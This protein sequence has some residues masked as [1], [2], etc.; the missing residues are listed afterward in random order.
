M[1]IAVVGGG[2]FGVSAAI[3]LAEKHTVHLYER[4]DDILKGA[5]GINQYRLHRGYHYPRS[6]HTASSSSSSESSFRKEF[7]QAILDNFDHYYC[8]AKEKS[9]ISGQNFLQFCNDNGLGYDFASLDVLNNKKIDVCIKVKESLYDPDKLRAVCKEKL[10]KANVKVMTNK[11]VRLQ[12]LKSYDYK[13]IATYANQNKLLEDYPEHQRDYQFELCEKPVVRLP[14][15]LKNKSIV[16][17]DGPFMCLD[18]LGNTG[19]SVLGNVVHA[20]HSANVGKHPKIDSRFAHLI[21]KGI[22]KNPEITN[23]S[24]FID[25]ASEFIPD[26][27]KAEH[28]GS[29]YTFR[30]VLPNVEHTDERPT[31]VKRL[32]KDIISIFSGKVGHSVDVADYI[33][34]MVNKQNRKI[35]NPLY[36]LESQ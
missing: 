20:I 25:S 36:S 19:F 13:I 5:S 8:I 29:M 30:T 2:I 35:A 21:D 31:I 4:Y 17:M 15:S 33:S 23:F 14:E 6:K 12:D 11:D 24:K 34:K 18:P 27:K 32:S 28:I 22:V 1:K 3:R 9:L 10:Q 16:I 7:S 26:M